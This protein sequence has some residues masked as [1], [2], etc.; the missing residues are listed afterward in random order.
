MLR[1]LPWIGRVTL[2]AFFLWCCI[3]LASSNPS[4]LADEESFEDVVVCA[5]L[6]AGTETKDCEKKSCIDLCLNAGEDPFECSLYCN[7]EA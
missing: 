6:G 3:A 5:G 7:L 2:A 4:S 1:R